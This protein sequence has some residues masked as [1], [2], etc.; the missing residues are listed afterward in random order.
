MDKPRCYVV[1]R[2]DATDLIPWQSSKNTVAEVDPCNDER[3]DKTRSNRVG[4]RASNKSNA[5]KQVE[6]QAHQSVDMVCHGQ[7]F[8][9]VHPE[10]VNMLKCYVLD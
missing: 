5:T 8:V 9:K 6:T 1:N 2:L 7:A 10:I 4:Q 3:V